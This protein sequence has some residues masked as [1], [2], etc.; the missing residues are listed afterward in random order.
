MQARELPRHLE[1]NSETCRNP[2]SE[3]SV[4]VST[5]EEFIIYN[6]DDVPEPED[7]TPDKP[8]QCPG[9]S[10]PGTRRRST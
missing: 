6:L 5:N 1:P 7:L 3:E 4:D 10:E 9:P 8:P 2:R